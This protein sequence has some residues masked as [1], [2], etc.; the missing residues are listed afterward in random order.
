MYR[1]SSGVAPITAGMINI[2][3]HD[4]AFEAIFTTLQATSWWSNG[5]EVPSESDNDDCNDF[6]PPAGPATLP[7]HNP[8]AEPILQSCKTNEV[9]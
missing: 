5:L 2:I 7:P 1:S 3:R 8:A 6:G 9:P 4:V